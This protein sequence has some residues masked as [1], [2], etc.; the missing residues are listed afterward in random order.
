MIPPPVFDQFGM[1]FF[2]IKD[3]MQNKEQSEVFI[4]FRDTIPV[5]TGYVPLGMVFGF[6]AV[7][8]GFSPF[9]AI[10]CSL[11]LYAGAVQYM[12]VP[13]VASGL[14][15]TVIAFATFVVNLRHIFYGIPLLETYPSKGLLRWYCV[16]TLTDETFSLL[17][18]MQG[19][20]SERRVFLISAFDHFWWNLGTAIGAFAGAQV[21][22]EFKGIDF[23][24]CCLFAMLATEQWRNRKTA[25]SL[26]SALIAYAVAYY[27]SAA[28]VLAISIA[29]CVL[30]CFAWSKYARKEASND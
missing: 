27:I 12:M 8:A 5:M 22:L 29:L 6:L 24:L 9:L 30:A 21:Q 10:T 2:E 4:A 14:P 28:N 16:Y 20:V 15:V 3:F 11:F 18:G 17:T 7:Q 13:M 25:W 26:Y 19:K 23:V 1:K